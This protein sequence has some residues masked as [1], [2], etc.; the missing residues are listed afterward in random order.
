MEKNKKEESNDFGSNVFFGKLDPEVHEVQEQSNGYILEEGVASKVSAIAQDTVKELEREDLPAFPANYQLYFERLLEKE[1]TSFKQKIQSVMDLQ[2]ITED[3]AVSFE[4]S[5]KE[6]FK[7][8]KQI[9]DF[10]AILYKNLQLMQT[11]TDKHIQGIEKIDN[12]IALSNAITLFVKDI[13]K[14]NSITS[15]QLSQ[16]KDLYQ[17]TAKV[18]SDINKNTVYDSR[19]GIYNKRYFMVLLEKE[20]KLM[21]EFNRS[22]SIL[23]VS[24]SREIQNSIEDKSTLMILLKSVAKLLLKTS[25]RSDIIG[26]LGDGIFGI[27]LK[28]S[29]I[30]SALK[31]TERFISSVKTTNI[32]LGDRDIALNISTGLAK[33]S[34]QRSADDSL[35]AALSA[36]QSALDKQEDYKIFPEDEG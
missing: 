36:L 18:I 27:G 2:S 31:A 4:K 22:S 16:I 10:I 5:V 11:I 9:L 3:R 15:S 30:P 17:K 1:E 29:D 23:V 12:K 20:N 19:F 28:Y 26:Y 25:R 35:S 7:N 14:V 24:L 34:P 8:I 32:F 6:G 33:I 21:E 13:D